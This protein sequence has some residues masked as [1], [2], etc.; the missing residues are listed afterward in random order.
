MHEAHDELQIT[1]VNRMLLQ[2]SFFSNK[3]EKIHEMAIKK[4]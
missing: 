3:K 4:S 1:S 2:I